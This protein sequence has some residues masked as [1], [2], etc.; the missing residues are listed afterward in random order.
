MTTDGFLSPPAEL[1]LNQVGA[2]VITIAAMV[3]IAVAFGYF[4]FETVRLRSPLPA[5]IFVS[6]MVWYPI[7]AFVDIPMAVLHN[8][9]NPWIAVTVL[10]RPLPFYVVSVGAAFFIGAWGFC[11]L[12]LRGASMRSLLI[13]GL[14]MGILDWIMEMASAQLG[15][16]S[17]YGNN[18][19]LI[20]G[21]PL[22]AMVQ[23]IGVYILQALVILWLAP[24]ARGWKSIGLLPVIPSV[25]I[26][27]AFGCTWPAYIAVHAQSAL[28]VAWPA[29]LLAVALNAAV[30]LIA[31]RAY[32]QSLLRTPRLGDS[33][34]PAAPFQACH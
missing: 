33:H 13:L 6:S 8:P 15:V 27:Y 32:F 29:I 17:Y 21:L 16:V 30:P 18:P 28:T 3:L 22:Y 24:H 14:A 25:Y 34:D 23:N 20:L 10:D 2:W 7:E 12:I 26:A 31:L 9:A 11:Q 1:A 19:S 4:L 5:V